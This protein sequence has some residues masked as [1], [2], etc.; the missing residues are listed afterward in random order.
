MT[1]P[2]PDEALATWVS[3]LDVAALPAAVA[4]RTRLLLLD[5]FASALAGVTAQEQPAVAALARELAGPGDATVIGG[6]PLAP[7]GAAFLNG[8]EVTAA[9]MCDVHRPTMTH[10]TPEVV[11]ATLA[12]VAVAAT[13]GRTV[14]GATVLAALAAGI[15]TTIR[16]AIAL[17]TD[18]AR[19]R[20]WHNPGVAGPFGAAAAAGRVLGLSPLEVAHAFGHAGG[21]AAGTFAALGTAGVKVH[22]ARGALSGLLAATLARRGLDGPA[23]SLTAEPG[24]LLHAYAGGGRPE[25]LTDGLGTRWH[26]DELTLRRWPGSSSVQAV[27]ECAL[28]LAADLGP[29]AADVAGV[30]V[31]LPPRSYELGAASTWG[32]QLGAMQSP[33]W[34][35][36]ATVADGAW[37]LGQVS[38]DRL[39]DASL[40]ARAAR[41]AVVRDEALPPAG[42]VVSLTLADATTRVA[43][44]DHPLG[45][46]D[47]PLTRDD[48]V[49]KLGAAATALDW[50]DRADAIVQAVDGLATARPSRRSCGSSLAR[51]GIPPRDPPRPV[52]RH[53]RQ[54][55]RPAPRRRH[56]P[57]GR[58]RPR[59]HDLAPR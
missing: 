4:D 43:R 8:F 56:R 40:G 54:R 33:G 26:L 5:A 29:A 19:E 57:P 48:V 9:T 28:E 2:V 13:D 7:L 41:V 35:V 51:K 37:G 14:D 44:R 53:P 6:T 49:A 36:T 12:A 17:D 47:R 45:S 11:P 1:A 3:T 39:A 52:V 30:E 15:E 18:A 50:H 59:A 42:A 27:V 31:R 34:V 25:A 58:H 38:P 32:D 46:P 24:G 16:V 10:V 55:A 22:Q 23:R 20:G 21:Q